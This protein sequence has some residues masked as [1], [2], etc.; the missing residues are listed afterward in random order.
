MTRKDSGALFIGIAILLFA[1]PQL[2]PLVGSMR[3][4]LSHRTF[5]YLL[6]A[7]DFMPGLAV[8]FLV[9]G[10][11]RLASKDKSTREN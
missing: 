2:E 4:S 5:Y 9:L 10:I 7:L 1:G 3:D 6:A 11:Y 8:I